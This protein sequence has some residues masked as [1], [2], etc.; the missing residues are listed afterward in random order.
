MELC[1]AVLHIHM[2]IKLH[3]LFKISCVIPPA[4]FKIG[5]GSEPEANVLNIGPVAVIMTAF[6]TG[7]CVIGYLISF[8]TVLTC[9]SPGYLINCKR[10]LFSRKR[11]LTGIIHIIKRRTLFNYEVIN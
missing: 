10:C 4:V 9:D 11:K 2:K 8:K 7:F 5:S 3:I 6:E 1:P